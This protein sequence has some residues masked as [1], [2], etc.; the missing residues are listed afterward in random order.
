MAIG[1]CHLFAA[2]CVS[3]KHHSGIGYCSEALELYG[4]FQSGTAVVLHDLDLCVRR[5]NCW[6]AAVLIG[7]GTVL[8]QLAALIIIPVC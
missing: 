5:T 2:E 1:I 7:L 3:L 6:V 4:S 8:K